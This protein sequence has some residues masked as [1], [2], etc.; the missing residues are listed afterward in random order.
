M[1]MVV[2][3]DS[4]YQLKKDQKTAD[5]LRTSFKWFLGYN[6]LD[7][8]LY[9]TDTSGCNDGIEE[10]SINRNQGAESTIAYHMAWLISAPYFEAEMPSAEVI[11]SVHDIAYN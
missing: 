11:L 8:P 3:Y 1:A 9:D 7:L 2:L 4:I 10:F 5:K 6:D